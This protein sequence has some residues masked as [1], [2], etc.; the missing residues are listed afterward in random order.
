MYTELVILTPMKFGKLLWRNECYLYDSICKSQ[1]V[2]LYL[3]CDQTMH[4]LVALHRMI[5]L[6]FIEYQVYV[7]LTI[8]IIPPVLAEFVKTVLI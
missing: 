7:E 5:L 1:L 8:E 2:I 4:T 6:F 3:N